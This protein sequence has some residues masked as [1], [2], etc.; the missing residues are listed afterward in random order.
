MRCICS[1]HCQKVTPLFGHAVTRA[2][3]AQRWCWEAVTALVLTCIPSGLMAGASLL[4][5]TKSFKELLL[6][7]HGQIAVRDNGLRIACRDGGVRKQL[8]GQLDGNVVHKEGGWWSHSRF[9]PC[10]RMRLRSW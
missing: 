3:S 7:Q 8:Q 1:S 9:L 4:F 10:R 2:K 6:C 5:N